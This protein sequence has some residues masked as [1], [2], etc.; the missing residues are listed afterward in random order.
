[1]LNYVDNK[2]DSFFSFK[3]GYQFEKTTLQVITAYVQKLDK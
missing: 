3:T 2:L 1:M